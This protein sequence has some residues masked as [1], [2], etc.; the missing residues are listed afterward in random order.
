VDGTD[1]CGQL[2]LAHLTETAICRYICY[3][4]SSIGAAF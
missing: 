3:S 2:N 1:K 4:V